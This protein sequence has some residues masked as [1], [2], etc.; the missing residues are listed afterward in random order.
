M[1]AN[2]NSLDG[3]GDSDGKRVVCVFSMSLSFEALSIY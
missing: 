2:T 3:I 1:L